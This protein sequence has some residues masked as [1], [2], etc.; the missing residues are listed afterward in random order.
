MRQFRDHVP[1]ERLV[2]RERGLLV[3]RAEQDREGELCGSGAAVSPAK[4]VRRVL[5]SIKIRGVNLDGATE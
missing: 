4:A 5:G 3:R 1:F 2:V